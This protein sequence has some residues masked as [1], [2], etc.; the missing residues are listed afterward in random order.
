MWAI[1]GLAALACV[2][3]FWAFWARR[4]LGVEAA[5]DWDYQIANNMQDLRLTKAAFVRAYRKVNMPRFSMYMAG[6]ALLILALTPIAFA[7]INV[8]LWG[9]WKFSG[10][11]R[12]FEPGYLVWEFSIFFALIAIWALIGA[13]VARKYHAGGPGLMRD[14]L[15]E[16]RAGFVPVR[17]L[18]VGANPVH[19]QVGTTNRA[20]YR[21][22][23]ES[24][25]GL[26]RQAVKNWNGTGHG[27]DIYSDGSDMEICVHNPAKGKTLDKDSHPF[28]FTKQHA[29]EDAIEIEYSIILKL[30]NAHAV[31]EDIVG[32]GLPMDKKTGNKTSRLRSFRHESVSLYLYQQ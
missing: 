16:E 31:F 30:E 23:F 26:E 32:L 22:L 11:S 17:P 19:I 24:A 8:G 29:R 10:E 20:A 25:L 7:L 1:G 12:V 13:F 18:V 15:I 6:G 14:E 28:F 9:V 27:C 2:F 3:G 21:K 5:T 4:R